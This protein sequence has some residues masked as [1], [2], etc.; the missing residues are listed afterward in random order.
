MKSKNFYIGIIS[1]P[2]L[3][4]IYF[5][6]QPY[7]KHILPLFD[8]QSAISDLITNIIFFLVFYSF[9]VTL[10][11]VCFLSKQVY[12]LN[13]K[14]HF[15]AV[16][17]L[18]LNQI[19]F[20]LFKYILKIIS[21]NFAAVSYDICNITCFAVS[22]YFLLIFYK[23][24]NRKTNRF[25]QL[26]LLTAVSMFILICIDFI[27]RFKITESLKLSLQKYT[28]N[29]YNL[30]KAYNDFAFKSQIISLI[31]ET[32][33]FIVIFS[34]T[35]FLYRKK[36]IVNAS[37]SHAIT[38]FI[39]QLFI[40]FIAAVFLNCKLLFL[41]VSAFAGFQQK[42]TG[43]DGINLLEK[44]FYVANEYTAIYRFITSAEL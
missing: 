18:F 16:G 5:I 32:I 41:P 27:I 31:I 4:M 7:L 26:I 44:N 39:A 37:T 19:I 20:D 1:F 29:S 6:W 34:I 14:K 36:S 35:Y 42:I 12:I 13:M 10:V 11:N 8:D 9:I 30:Q 17:I 15:W 3:N 24:A 25:K 22:L 28:A 40:I 43:K 23:A 21:E 38:R 2:V 33:G